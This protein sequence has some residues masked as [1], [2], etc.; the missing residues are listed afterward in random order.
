MAASISRRVVLLVFSLLPVSPA[1]AAKKKKTPTLDLLSYV[2]TLK[3]EEK[4]KQEI[5]KLIEQRTEAMLKY[6]TADSRKREAATRMLMKLDPTSN[7]DKKKKQRIE[8]ALKAL[9]E[10]RKRYEWTWNFK[11]LQKLGKEQKIPWQNQRLQNLL[12][13]EFAGILT[14][15]EQEEKI[16]KFTEEAL[17]KAPPNALNMDL[18]NLSNAQVKMFYSRTLLQGIYKTILAPDQQKVWREAKIKKQQEQQ[19]KDKNK[20]R[21]RIIVG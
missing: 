17:K 14:G 10:K 4:A 20:K 1:G 2:S 16:Q 12:L 8:Q 5:D 18:T 7:A 15:V 11:I 3:L 6:D 9:E 19:K 13:D 21:G